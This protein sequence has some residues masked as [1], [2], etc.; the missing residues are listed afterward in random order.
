M[1]YQFDLSLHEMVGVPVVKKKTVS[2]SDRFLRRFL[3]QKAPLCGNCAKREILP[4]CAKCKTDYN[5]V[6]SGNSK[7][8]EPLF[9]QGFPARVRY[10]RDCGSIFTDQ[11]VSVTLSRQ[12]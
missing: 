6:F 11:C 2:V 3:C 5:A 9:Q 12:T 10:R 8:T 7:V 1:G 4:T